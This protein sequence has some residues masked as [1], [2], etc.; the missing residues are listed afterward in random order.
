MAVSI[1]VVPVR[2][3]LFGRIGEGLSLVRRR[4]ALT[5][6]WKAAGTDA[7]GIEGRAVELDLKQQP[8]GKYQLRLEA[9]TADGR[10]AASTLPLELRP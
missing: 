2:R 9:R 5:L 8:T 3:G 7:P 4:G 1:T 6:A 10:T